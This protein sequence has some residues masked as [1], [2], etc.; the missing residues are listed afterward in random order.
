MKIVKRGDYIEKGGFSKFFRRDFSIKGKAGISPLTFKGNHYTGLG[1][2]LLN[3]MQSNVLDYIAGENHHNEIIRVDYSPYAMNQTRL[4]ER[5]GIDDQAVKRKYEEGVSIDGIE[6]LD[7]DDAIWVEKTR[8]GYAV[9]VHISDVT[10]AVQT[11]T[12]LDIEALKRTTSIYR[13]EGVINMFPPLLSQNLLSLNENGEKLTLSMQ[14][15]L[16]ENAQIRD[17][18]VYESTFKN[19]RRYDYETF[20]DDFMNPDSENHGTLQL[21]YEIAR[22][23]RIVRRTEGANMDY[24]ESDRQLSVGQRTEKPHSG[25]KAIP[26]TIIEEFMILANITS[27]MISVKNRYDSVFRLHK[28]HDERAFYHNSVGNHT[29]LALQNY[30]HFTS[31]IRRY[32]D[33][34][35]H[36]VLKIVHLRGEEPPYSS[37]EIGDIAKYINFS[38]TVIDILGKDTDNELRGRNLVSKLKKTNGNTLNVSHFTQNLR[39]TVGAG[40]K[41]PRVVVDEIINDLENGEKSN[42]AWAIGVLLVS[43]NE[44]I[45][46]YLKKALLDD[47]KFRAISVIALLNTT[48]ISSTDEAYLF[49]IEEREEGNEFSIA[50]YFRRKELFNSSINYGKIEA[51][52]AIGRMRNKILKRIVVHFCGK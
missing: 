42:W 15:D 4:I 44:D 47:K 46:K 33:M 10:E 49:H 9:F 34:I 52:D 27:A 16:D 20:V 51:K 43:G 17:F 7:L 40:K 6:S 14:I 48:R 18:H 29:G 35:V 3:I 30:T 38:R 5:N 11:Y 36:R 28:A 25:S 24:D 26:T 22:K 2:F 23:R 45:K 32:S 19:K 21:M 50:V 8:K 37:S 31:P 39:S 13:A 41:M 12:P 1:I